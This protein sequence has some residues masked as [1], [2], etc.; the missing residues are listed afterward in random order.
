MNSAPMTPESNKSGAGKWLALTAAL[1]GWMFDG[2][3]MGLFS[4]VGRVAIKDLMTE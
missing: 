3:E 1:L 2:A 4:M